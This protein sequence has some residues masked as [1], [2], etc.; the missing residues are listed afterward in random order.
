[1]P[2]ER[3]ELLARVMQ[4]SSAAAAAAVT[5]RDA[6]A[7]MGDGMDKFDGFDAELRMRARGALSR[8]EG[9]GDLDAGVREIQVGSTAWRW[10]SKMPA[11]QRLPLPMLAG[12]KLFPTVASAEGFSRPPL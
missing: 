12:K 11:S 6:L 7:V 1:M 8:E 2:A 10:C 5:T 4:P 9:M 3:A